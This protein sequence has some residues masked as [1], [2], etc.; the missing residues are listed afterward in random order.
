[1]SCTFT[2]QVDIFSTDATTMLIMLC[3]NKFTSGG[4]NYIPQ[5]SEEGWTDWVI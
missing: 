1:M 3:S 5:F 2:C 4:K